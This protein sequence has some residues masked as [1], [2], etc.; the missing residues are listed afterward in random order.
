M[1]ATT[2]G[3]KLLTLLEGVVVL[4]FDVGHAAESSLAE[5][6]FTYASSLSR[7]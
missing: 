5:A 2:Y 6:D 1:K 7:I 3:Y 4:F